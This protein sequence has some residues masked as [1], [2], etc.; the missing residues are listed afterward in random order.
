MLPK[1]PLTIF[2][3]A[4]VC[5]LTVSTASQTP[6]DEFEL[7]KPIE[8]KGLTKVYIETVGDL[9]EEERIRERIAKAKIPGLEVVDSVD[10]AEIVLFFA[11]G[12]FRATTGATSNPIG[13]SVS[14]TVTTISLLAGEGRAFVFSKESGKPRLVLRVANQ[15]DNKA[16]KRPVTKF[17]E[18]FARAYRL[19]NG[20][21]KK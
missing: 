2:V 6:Y 4:V 18:E 3:F 8:L 14:T 15:Q 7:G 9:K 12:S 17:V 1:Y 20:L 21:P 5:F 11:G 19:A 16:E 13:N 10:D